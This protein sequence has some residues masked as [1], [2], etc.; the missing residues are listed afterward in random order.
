MH[1]FIGLLSVSLFSQQAEPLDA[2]LAQASSAESESKKYLDSRRVDQIGAD[3]VGALLER[4][5]SGSA[6]QREESE[7][8]LL[9]L[10]PAILAHLP[11][12]TSSDTGVYRE[13]LDRIRDSMQSKAIGEYSQPSTVTLKGKL[14]VGD[15][16]LEIMEQTDNQLTI[17]QLPAQNIEVNFEKA[18]FWE[19][20]DSVLDQLKLE[21]IPM[22]QDSSLKL[23]PIKSEGVRS[24]RGAYA[25]VFRIEP[26]RV[27][28][29]RS[30]R[31]DRLSH[32][33]LEIE[34][35]WEPRLRPA[36]FNF[37]MGKLLVECDNGEILEAT[38]LE[39]SPEYTPTDAHSIEAVLMVDLPSRH[40]KSIRR[41]SGTLMAA[42]PGA[43][44]Q[45]EFDNLDQAGAKNQ[46]VGNLNVTVEEMKQRDEIYEF[47]ILISLRDAGQT[48]D[49]FR[50]WFM[51]HEAYV[52]NAKGERV[53][54]AGWQTYLMN[55]ES[56]GLTYFFDLGPS[57]KGC[58]LVYSAPGAVAEQRVDF[59]LKDIPLP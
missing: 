29:T 13:T 55:G 53:N 2:P 46:K 18:T 14:S 57:V 4:I 49:S 15:V 9:Q 23:V 39:S 59:I 10:G 51:S 44:V 40:A 19:A 34:L 5:Q 33:N 45:L 32:L 7:R 48:M 52:K 24:A 56:V 35:M 8:T 58:R 16:L 42:I 11:R 21:A 25:G 22:T 37:P 20:L 54:N 41:L 30:L 31:A 38:S 6:P 3:Q 27:D 1:L 36:Y 26:V 17:E 47:K 12:F 28:A 43:M 50:G